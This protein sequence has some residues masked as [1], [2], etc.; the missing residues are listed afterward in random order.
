MCIRDRGYLARFEHIARLQTLNGYID[1]DVR[2]L[3]TSTY[4][5]VGKSVSD[6]LYYWRS[7]DLSKRSSANPSTPRLGHGAIG[8]R[9][10]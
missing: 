8:S 2:Q 7:L 6:D 5:F 3:D 4:Y 10:T 9:S 1:G